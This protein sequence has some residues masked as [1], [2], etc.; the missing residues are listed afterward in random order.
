MDDFFHMGAIL[1]SSRFLGRA[2]AA[3]VA[4]KEGPVKVLEVGAGT[5][6]F[7]QE[8]VPLLLP[9]DSLDL[10][11]ISPRLMSYLQERFKKE[12]AFQL[13]EGVTVNFINDD[14]RNID[15]RPKYDYIVFSLPL[16]NFPPE[17]VREILSLMLACLKPGGVFSYVKYA[18]ISRF[19]YVFG[20]QNIR[21]EM[22]TKQRII[23][24]FAKQYE[25]DRRIVWLNVPPTWTFFWQ[26]PLNS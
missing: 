5:G 23:Q 11:E 22:D 12:A 8:I 25:I 16:T 10:V 1:P 4:E 17:M 9:G 18:F 14:V 7:T 19:K 20:G 2:G 13:K 21:E 24:E 6:S 15:S 26:K 3:Y